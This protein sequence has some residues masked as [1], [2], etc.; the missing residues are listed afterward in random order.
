MT[1]SPYELGKQLIDNRDFLNTE[2]GGKKVALQMQSDFCNLFKEH[3][4]Y[5]KQIGPDKFQ[6]LVEFL[7]T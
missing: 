5:L 7:P 1:Y 4:L 3:P 2:D 6:K